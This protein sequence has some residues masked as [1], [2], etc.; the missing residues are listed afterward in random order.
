VETSRSL[1]FLLL[2]VFRRFHA[3]TMAK[4]A[5]DI[6]VETAIVTLR[7][8]KRLGPGTSTLKVRIGVC[9]PI[10][11][12]LRDP[13]GLRGLTLVSSLLFSSR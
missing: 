5:R 12:C 3:V 10:N 6:L 11:H 8:E 13:F 7:L 2:I 9:A 1:R 4:F